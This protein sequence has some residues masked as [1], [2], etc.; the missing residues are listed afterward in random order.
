M[1]LQIF[2]NHNYNTNEAVPGLIACLKDKDTNVKVQACQALARIGS[3]AQ[4]AVPAL[5]ELLKEENQVIRSAAQ[6]ALNMIEA[7]KK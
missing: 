3:S 1:T 2:Q 4:D 5:N 7:K 6:N